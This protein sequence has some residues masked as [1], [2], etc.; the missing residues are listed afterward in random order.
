MKSDKQNAESKTSQHDAN[1]DPLSGRAGAHP[2]GTGLGAVTGGVAGGAATG[3]V[4]G[5]M[6][7]PVG[8]VV[9]AAAGAV[10][11]AV[12]GGA[13]GKGIAEAI[14]PTVEHGFWRSS[15]TNRPYVTKGSRY[16]EYAPAYQYGWESKTRHHDKTFEQ[17]E[18][19]LARD[20]NQHRGTSTLDWEHAKPAAMDSWNRV[21]QRRP[22]SVKK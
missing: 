18:P 6:A 8:T 16:E 17:S 9:G 13:A 20:W 14:D 1:R 10:V 4:V 12:V 22:E 5:T 19:Y 15:Y 3:A 21:S 2:I 11:G 7:G